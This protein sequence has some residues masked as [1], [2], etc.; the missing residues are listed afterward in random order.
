[1]RDA[2]NVDLCLWRSDCVLGCA[3]ENTKSGVFRCGEVGD[4]ELPACT[5]KLPEQGAPFQTMGGHD[6]AL[7][8]CTGDPRSSQSSSSLD[9]I[10][11]SRLVNGVPGV[12][13]KAR[14]TRQ[15]GRVNMLWCAP[16]RIAPGP[17]LGRRVAED[18][19]GLK[20]CAHD[21]RDSGGLKKNST[22]IAV[23]HGRVVAERCWD[24]HSECR[25][26]KK[27]RRNI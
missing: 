18:A 12:D 22:R 25:C 8:L 5:P 2:V 20:L 14:A 7:L 26:K 16:Y 23:S 11:R 3:P 19:R 9:Q 24:R 15:G 13:H 1:M 4:A 17:E 27:S 6:T 21:S 10:A